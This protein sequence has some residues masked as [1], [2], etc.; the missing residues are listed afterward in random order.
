MEDVVTLALSNFAPSEIR[1]SLR[2][3]YRDSMEQSLLDDVTVLAS[4]IVTNSVVHSGRPRGDAITV[5]ATTIDGTLRVQVEDRGKGVHN[6]EPASIEPPSGLGYVQRLSDRWS[7]RSNGSFQV[8]FEIDVV[9]R[10]M[11]HRAAS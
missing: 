7:S 3:R 2:A 6:L 1:R 5:T 4:E 11:L 8:W 9:N 10:T